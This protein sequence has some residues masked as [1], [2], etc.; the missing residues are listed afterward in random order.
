MEVLETGGSPTVEQAVESSP[1]RTDVE[2]RRGLRANFL[3][4]AAVLRVLGDPLLPGPTR[5]TYRG[6]LQMHSEWSDGVPTLQEI[7]EGCLARGYEYS[8]VTDHSHGLPIAGGMSLARMAEQDAEIDRVNAIYAGRFRLLKGIEANIGADGV[9]DVSPDEIEGLDVVLAAPHSKLRRQEDQTARM[10]QALDT[11]GVCILAHPRGRMVGSRTGVLADWDRVF[12][13]AAAT[14]V[15]VEI[16]GDPSRQDLDYT[17]AVRALAAGC[18]FALD[19]D[20]HTVEQLRYAETALAHARLA[21][22]PTARIVNC[23]PLDQLVDWLGKRKTPRHTSRRHAA[24]RAQTPSKAPSA[25][26]RRRT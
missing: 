8:A 26:R 16:D 2:R 11:P 18:L 10:L 19:S 5:S 13:R 23:W 21:G 20:A 24:P 6:D 1:K 17:V 25:S 9:L 12:E 22:I 4:R 7:V 15:A 3:S 14:G